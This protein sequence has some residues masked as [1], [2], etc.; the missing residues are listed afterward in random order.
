[1]AD[2]G[3]SEPL[4]PRMFPDKEGAPPGLIPERS[5]VPERAPPE[6]EESSRTAGKR[7]IPRGGTADQAAEQ[8]DNI[9]GVRKGSNN[10]GYTKSSYS[11]DYLALLLIV[12][13]I[14]RRDPG[15]SMLFPHGAINNTDVG[16][17]EAIYRLSSEM[18]RKILQTE[19][20]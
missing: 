16:A 4:N 8:I 6:T 15:Y 3:S 2:S 1:M 5:L 9:T 10:S 20:D 17:T 14:A 12:R 11:Q 18:K 13:R 19:A 7:P